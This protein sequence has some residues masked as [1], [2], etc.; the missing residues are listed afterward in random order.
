[1]ILSHPIHLVSV[2]LFLVSDLLFLLIDLVLKNLLFIHHLQHALL[3]GCRSLRQRGVW[4]REGSLHANIH[5]GHG[6]WIRYM[7]QL[8]RLVTTHGV[9]FP[10]WY[11]TQNWLAWRWDFNLHIW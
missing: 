4:I 3:V 11:V 6:S 9:R 1:M 5:L 2:V 7:H 8:R 10:S